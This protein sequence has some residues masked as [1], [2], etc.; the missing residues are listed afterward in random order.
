[1]RH[2]NYTRHTEEARGGRH[3]LGVIAGG[4]CHDPAS[5]LRGRDRGKLV[6]GAA[7]FKRPS[8][9]QRLGFEEDPSAGHGIERRRRK[10]RRMQSHA[11]EPARG[12]V[13]IRGSRQ[14]SRN[15]H[16]LTVALRARPKQGRDYELF[17]KLRLPV[18]RD[19]VLSST[20]RGTVAG[21]VWAPS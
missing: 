10:Q 20:P 5:S 1:M 7:E 4:E 8:A 21:V 9:L 19:P 6:V 17:A 3:T 18:E 12:L 14:G 13:D 16:G 2:D 15:F 11:G